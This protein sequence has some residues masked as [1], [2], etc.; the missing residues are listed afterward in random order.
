MKIFNSSSHNIKK[1]Q[2][3]YFGV[4][5]QSQNVTSRESS[6]EKKQ[7][8]THKIGKQMKQFQFSKIIYRYMLK[9]TDIKINN[10]HIG[11]QTNIPDMYESAKENFSNAPKNIALE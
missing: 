7:K 2:L 11:Q 1:K 3:T 9:H 5:S 4:E 6:D 10:V 8:N